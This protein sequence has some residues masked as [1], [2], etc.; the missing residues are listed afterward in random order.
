VAR[1]LGRSA[2]RMERIACCALLQRR[3]HAGARP[4]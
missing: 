4:D 1:A 3:G 2:G